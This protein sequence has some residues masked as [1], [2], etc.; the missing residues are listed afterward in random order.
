M[1]TPRAHVKIL[2]CYELRTRRVQ[3]FI[4]YIRVVHMRAFPESL[5][6]HVN[7]L[8]NTMRLRRTA[9]LFFFGLSLDGD[10][11]KKSAVSTRVYVYIITCTWRSWNYF[12]RYVISYCWYM[13]GGGQMITGSGGGGTVWIRSRR[14]QVVYMRVVIVPAGGPLWLGWCI[15]CNS[16]IF[17]I[18]YVRKYNYYCNTRALGS[19]WTSACVILI[20]CTH[21]VYRR[22]HN[23]SYEHFSR[24]TRSL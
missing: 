19:H 23:A 7:I 1:Y 6:K 5:C 24:R 10:E 22:H 21:N 20:R 17:N 18:I 14:E 3:I 12:T 8:Y 2:F 11:R 9:L 16:R 13:E 15:L 4:S